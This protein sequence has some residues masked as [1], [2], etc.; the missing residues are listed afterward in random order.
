VPFVHPLQEFGPSDLVG[1]AQLSE[2]VDVALIP[3]LDRRVLL[4]RA[5]GAAPVTEGD[6]L[7]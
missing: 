1:E 7:A 5:V 3:L 2:V 6:R 4:N